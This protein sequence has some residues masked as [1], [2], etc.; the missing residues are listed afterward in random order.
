MAHAPEDSGQGR[1]ADLVLPAD[2]R[3]Y[4]DDVIRV[5]RMPHAEEKPNRDDGKKADHIP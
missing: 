3:R 2:N 4:G 1:A 5:S